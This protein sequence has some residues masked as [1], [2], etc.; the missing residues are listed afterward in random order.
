MEKSLNLSVKSSSALFI[1]DS[2]KNAVHGISV[3]ANF[4]VEDVL[5]AKYDT[6]AVLEYSTQK[7]VFISTST[8]F[9]GAFSNLYVNANYSQSDIFVHSIRFPQILSNLGLSLSVD[10]KKYLISHGWPKIKFRWNYYAIYYCIKNFKREKNLDRLKI[11][12]ELIF[13]SIAIDQYRHKDLD[14]ASKNDISYHHYNFN[15]QF[16][17]YCKQ[18]LMKIEKSGGSDQIMIIANYERV[19][20]IWWMAIY[21]LKRKL[22]NKA[23]KHFI[24]FIQPRKGFSFRFFKFLAKSSF[25][26]IVENQSTKFELLSNA[27]YLFIPSF[28]EYNPIVALE[29]AVCNKKVVSLYK[30]TALAGNDNYHY[31]LK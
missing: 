20:N 8:F 1:T 17:S 11:Y 13:I 19:K 23:P 15:T 9:K 21:N 31:I 24:L 3:F 2:F 16:I 26:Q 12:D 10:V 25:I 7:V 14:W 5:K 30:I 29:A 18:S 28:T 22:R 27:K 6:I 4:F